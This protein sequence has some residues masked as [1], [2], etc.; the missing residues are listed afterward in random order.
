MGAEKDVDILIKQAHAM[1][2]KLEECVQQI[3]HEE[4]TVWYDNGG[5]QSGY[6]ENPFFTAYEKLLASY[7]K[8]VLA[9]KNLS[10]DEKKEEV[11]TLDSLRERFKVAK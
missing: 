2:E 3:P 7:T 10:G 1:A 11:K 9:I 8:T 5:G 4:L 6:R